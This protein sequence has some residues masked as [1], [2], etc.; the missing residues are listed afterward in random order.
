LERAAQQQLRWEQRGEVHL[1][2]C[3]RS[4]EVRAVLVTRRQSAGVDGW[5]VRSLRVSVCITALIGMECTMGESSVS[6]IRLSAIHLFLKTSREAWA[7][8]CSR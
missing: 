2:A 3:T 8:R 5:N 6:T 4:L 1:K 7:A